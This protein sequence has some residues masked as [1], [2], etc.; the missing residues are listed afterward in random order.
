MRN[1]LTRLYRFWKHVFVHFYNVDATTR[2]ASLAYTSLLSSVPLAV[3]G[4][5]IFSAFPVFEEYSDKIQRF[6]ITHFVAAS[7]DTIHEYIIE[8]ASKAASLS[9]TSLLF[10]LIAAVMLVFTMESALNAIWQIET[11][12]HGATA[13]LIYWAVLTLLPLLAGASIVSSM[14]LMSLPYIKGAAETIGGVIPFLE[15][16]P[17][18]LMWMGFTAL[19]VTLPNKKVF[20]LDAF[21]G[22]LAAALLFESI[23]RGFG[24]YIQFYSTYELVYG[25]LSAVPILLVWI[26]VSWLIILF[27]AVISFVRQSKRELQKTN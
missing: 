12:R 4:I 13:F 5:S 20:F 8:F 27:G 16:F 10:V 15:V 21:L 25:A 14:Y 7:A 17:F 9:A 19:Y 24:Y 3:V 18:F 2:A 6:L 22:A 26:Y 11:R 23:K 1:Y